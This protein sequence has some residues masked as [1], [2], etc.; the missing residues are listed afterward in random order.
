M[1]V[2]GIAI[3]QEEGFQ[4]RKGSKTV[5]FTDNKIMYV[6]NTINSISKAPKEKE[7]VT[8]K[9]APIRLAADLSTETLK[10]RREW[11]EIF[12][13]MKSKGLQPRLLYPERLSV[14]K[15]GK[16]KSFPDKGRL[17]EYTSMKPVIQIC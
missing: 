13:V 7:K 3:R 17:K 8:Y 10:S 12:Q 9:E 1:E 5:I 4:I 15:Q 14:K 16:M 11:Q 6:E 2:L